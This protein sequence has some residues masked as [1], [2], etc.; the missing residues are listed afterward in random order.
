MSLLQLRTRLKTIRS[1][2]SI[3]SALEVVTVVRTKRVRE[4]YQMMERYLQPMREVLAGRVREAKTAQ[5]VLVVITSN[6]GLCG[7]FN[8]L[9]TAKAREFLARNPDA[10]LVFI[11]RF[12]AVRL[13]KMSKKVLFSVPEIVEKTSFAKVEELAA[14]LA[15]LGA[16]IYIAYN[17]YKSAVVQIPK[18][19]RYYPVPEELTTRQNP[20]EFILEPEPNDVTAEMFKHYLCVRLFQVLLD[21]QM[22]ELSAR[23]MVL[24]GAIDT[25]KELTDTL[26]IQINK[27]R[28]GAI[29][30]D[31]LEIV[32]AAEALR[33]DDD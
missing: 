31:L 24:N 11:G 8:N 32:S 12:G 5:K 33:R 14:K 16:E 15:G 27:A 3:F 29:T 9:V 19:Y 25:S 22:G 17:S 18:L 13:G 2:N 20:A 26:F 28:Q 1:L 6:R 4:P 30:K 21:S 10:A 7:S 23:L